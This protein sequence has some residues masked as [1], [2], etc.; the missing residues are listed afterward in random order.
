M[1]LCA[2]SRLIAPRH[3]TTPSGWSLS[4]AVRSARP[5]ALCMAGANAQPAIPSRAQSLHANV[6]CTVALKKTTAVPT[7]LPFT[8]QLAGFSP[9]G[10]Q[11][12]ARNPRTRRPFGLDVTSGS[13]VSGR[14]N[15]QDLSLGRSRVTPLRKSSWTGRPVH[16][17]EAGGL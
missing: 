12:P 3:P 14:A 7:P 17:S 4:Q 16:R 15:P 8:D 1:Q 11:P 13:Q 6:A 2:E 9:P 10:S 5:A